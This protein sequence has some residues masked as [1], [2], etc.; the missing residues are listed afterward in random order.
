MLKALLIVLFLIALFI[1]KALIK[2][3]KNR[4]RTEWGSLE[5]LRDLI[6]LLMESENEYS[7]LRINPKGCDEFFQITGN[8]RGI[9]INFPLVTEGQIALRETV[10]LAARR[11]E[12]A[13]RE[14]SGSD[15]SKFL[16][17]DINES[18]DRITEVML[19]LMHEV[20][21]TKTHDDIKYEYWG[22]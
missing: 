7:F 12:I 2:G 20:F 16:D 19:E 8:N 9:Q 11:G 18:P 3:W 6:P 4:T 17:I 13:I 15:G 1:G 10:E 21:Q 14:T 22:M 5:K